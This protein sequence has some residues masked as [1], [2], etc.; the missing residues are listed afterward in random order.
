M[1]LVR[2][3]TASWCQRTN[4]LQQRVQQVAWTVVCGRLPESLAQGIDEKYLTAN[5]GSLYCTAGPPINAYYRDC[6]Y[7]EHCTSSV[8]EGSRDPIGEDLIG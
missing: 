8:P 6:S 4:S 7:L 3:H 5:E 2:T 1:P